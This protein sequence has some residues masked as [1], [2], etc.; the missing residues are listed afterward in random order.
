MKRRGLRDAQQFGQTFPGFA[1]WYDRWNGDAWCWRERPDSAFRRDNDDDVS[2]GRGYRSKMAV[3]A[4]IRAELM[5]RQGE[6]ASAAAGGTS[7][8]R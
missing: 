3:R 5:R 7:D 8:R 1:I 2:E 4:A 6:T